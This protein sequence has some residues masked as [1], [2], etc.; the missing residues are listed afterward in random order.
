MFAS[1]FVAALLLVPSVLAVPFV[2]APV[3]STTWTAGAAQNIVWEDDGTAPSLAQFGNATV[4]IYA[5]NQ[6]QQT[7][8][9]QIATVNVSSTGTVTFTPDASMGPNG[10]YY[11]VRLTSLAYMDGQYPAEAFS[12]KFTMAGMSGTFN[13]SVSAE[14]AGAS[15][16]PVGGSST[17]SPTTPSPS[18]SKASSSSGSAAPS[19]SAAG[20]ASSDAMS[21]VPRSL[22]GLAGAAV[23]VISSMFF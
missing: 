17:S 3:A 14:V 7:E 22:A 1:A 8:L 13:A 23:V 2:T 16:A 4:G 21:L 9:Q 15:T 20:A 18:T 10:N 6:N 5:G 11:F 19:G 12:A